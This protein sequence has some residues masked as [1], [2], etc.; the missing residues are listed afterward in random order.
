MPAIRIQAIT[1]EDLQL[2]VMLADVP[3]QGRIISRLE[4]VQLEH[5]M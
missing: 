3:S 5:A 2:K 1:T 4:A